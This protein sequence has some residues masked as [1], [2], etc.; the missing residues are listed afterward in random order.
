MIFDLTPASNRRCLR[1]GRAT[2]RPLFAAG[3]ALSLAIAGPP[4]RTP[5]MPPHQTSVTLISSWRADP[6]CLP[7][8]GTGLADSVF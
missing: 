7:S 8:C 4:A 6:T 5:A 2:P 3:F 1:A